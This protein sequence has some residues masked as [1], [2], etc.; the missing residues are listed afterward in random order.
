MCFEQEKKSL[1]LLSL[2]GL[3][4]MLEVPDSRIVWS[5]LGLG[6]CLLHSFDLCLDSNLK[7][8]LN[9]PNLILLKLC[10][11]WVGLFICG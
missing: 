2:P 11:R 3:L 8:V 7:Y 9:K 5:G 6:L 4:E 10:Y 1:A